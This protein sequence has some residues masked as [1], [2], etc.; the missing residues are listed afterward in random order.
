VSNGG[1]TGEKCESGRD[2]IDTLQ[3][4]FPRK[5]EEHHAIPVSLA[6]AQLEIPFLF[7]CWLF[8]YILSTEIIQLPMA[9]RL[10]SAEQSVG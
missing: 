5:A 3:G 10:L 4:H 9:G 2:H 8:D 1:V 6:D 7:F